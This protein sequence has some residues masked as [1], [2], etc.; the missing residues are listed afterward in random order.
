MSH[1]T[2]CPTI[3][4][5]EVPE[6]SATEDPVRSSPRIARFHT[7]AEYY[8]FIEQKLFVKLTS[9]TMALFIWFSAHYVFNLK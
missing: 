2:E 8:V 3:Q 5:C 1:Y 4:M 6:I 7:R 9:F